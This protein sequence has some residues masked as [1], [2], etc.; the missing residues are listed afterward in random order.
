M[1]EEEYIDIVI[2]AVFS[3]EHSKYHEAVGYLVDDL[4]VPKRRDHYSKEQLKSYIKR[5]LRRRKK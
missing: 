1:T 3:P 2:E 4:C 5:E